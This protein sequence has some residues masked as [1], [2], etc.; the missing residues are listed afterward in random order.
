MLLIITTQ[1]ATPPSA[2]P[3]PSTRQTVCGGQGMRTFST[4]AG[5]LQQS[6]QDYVGTGP[7]AGS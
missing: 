6:C 2:A 1:H 4:R 3:G 7:G 5:F